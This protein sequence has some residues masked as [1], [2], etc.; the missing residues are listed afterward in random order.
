[1]PILPLPTEQG[2]FS[3]SDPFWFFPRHWFSFLLSLICESL[4]MCIIEFGIHWPQC[5]L[6]FYCKAASSWWNLALLISISDLLDTGSFIIQGKSGYETT[7]WYP[8]NRSLS[9][10][11]LC[12]SSLQRIRRRY[13]KQYSLDPSRYSLFSVWIAGQLVGNK[14]VIFEQRSIPLFS[15]K[16]KPSLATYPAGC[17]ES[18]PGLGQA[19]VS[20]ST[21]INNSHRPVSIPLWGAE[22]HHLPWGPW[23]LWAR[24]HFQGVTVRCREWT[25]LVVYFPCHRGQK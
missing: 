19:E 22:S 5:S 3:S 1:M 23:C 11:D 10:W 6:S 18:P 15:W 13:K 17:G 8:A 12:K 24:W 2:V 14:P 9:R 20:P 21:T 4:R 25:H 7:V 16:I